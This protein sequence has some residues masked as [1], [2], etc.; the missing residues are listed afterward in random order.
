MTGPSPP[1][2]AGSDD[3]VAKLEAKVAALESMVVGHADW[4][5]DL[6]QD[7]INGTEAAAGV[8]QGLA[9]HSEWLTTLER[10]VSSCVKTLANF[11]AQPLDDAEPAAS[12]TLDVTGTLMARLE[13]LTV[14]DW[15]AT[16][17]DVPEGPTV[18]VTVATRERPLLLRQAIDSVLQQSYR[19]LELVV[20]DDSDSDDTQQLLATIDDPRLRTVR[21]PARRGA[22]AVYNVGLE[23]ATG[24]IIAFLDDDNV[25]H[26]EWLRS[27]VWSFSTFTDVRA[28][29]GART[30]EDPG[31]Q[32]GIRSGMLP[33]LEFAHYDRAR[34]ER[35]NYIDRNTIAFRSRLRDIRYD[36]SLRAAFDWDHSLRLFAQAEPLALPALSCYY[37]TV[38]PD[39]VS[40]IHD[41]GESVRRVRARVHATRPLRVL[42][43]TA[44]Y[45]VVSE[46]YIGEDIDALEQAGAVV[47]VSALQEAVSRAEGA[48]LCRLDVD[49]VIE[50]TQPDVVL[51]HWSTHA[52]GE[53][54]RMERHGQPFACRVHSFDVDEDR[55]RRIMDHPLCVGVFAHPHHLGGL[56]DGVQPLIPTVSPKTVIPA[57]QS[58]R[59]LVLSVSAG[60]P[61]K[62][63]GFLIDV[64]AR[65]PEVERMIILA[66]SNGIEDL[67]A[68]VE[69][70]A[71]QV[72][73][74]IAVRVNVPR[75]DV[76][77]ALSRSYVLIY[78]L[79]SQLPMGFPMSIIEAMLC[80]AIVIAPDR[81]EA[82]AIVGPHLRTFRG[83]DDIVRHVHEVVKGGP[84]LEAAR[85]E[86]VQR[87]QRHRDPAELR[88]L[89]D[90]LRDSL[91]AWRTPRV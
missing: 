81:P 35:A 16:V 62:E 70:L 34:H 91:T 2:G 40:D 14:M 19:R 45:P 30:N 26:P 80:G 4:I 38:L 21:T 54:P 76:L 58:E 32:R 75:G 64:L 65:M 88:R 86:L 37:R 44:M 56:P 10:W 31:A 9:A 6:Q 3:R 66:R 15:I 55:V 52:E 77:A 11:G 68:E 79:D 59:N 63:F 47:T 25:M 87:A 12:G 57:S 51:L 69:R 83:A 74:S 85:R 8:S 22:G 48:P 46:T 43:H 13:V 7:V 42:V 60:L 50:E 18:S 1:A 39:R 17:A 20:M 27:V 78:T 28:L 89:H 5:A 71:L 29:Y 24:D 53:I 49:A 67:P 33:T 84:E 82:H 41:Q 72:D 36:E 61:K 73:P 23:A 90:A